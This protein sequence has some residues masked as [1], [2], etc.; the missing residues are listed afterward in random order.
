MKHTAWSLFFA[1]LLS[2]SLSSV[3]F[4][5]TSYRLTVKDG[6]L[7]VWDCQNQCWTEITDTPAASL[8]V[9]DRALLQDGISCSEQELQM[10]L[11]DYC[12]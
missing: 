9:A 10:L 12:S 4:A 5:A 1:V 2:I 11:Q 8:P 3:C 7:A 6:Y